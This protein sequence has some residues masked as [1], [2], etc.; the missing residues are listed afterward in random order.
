MH[1]PKVRQS[2]ELGDNVINLGEVRITLLGCRYKLG[3]GYTTK[4]Y[5]TKRAGSYKLERS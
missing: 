1:L 2:L 5:T 4:R 3:E